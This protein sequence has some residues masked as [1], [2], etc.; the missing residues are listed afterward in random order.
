MIATLDLTHGNTC[1]TEFVLEQRFKIGGGPRAAAEQVQTEGS[2]FGEGVAGKVR[3]RKQAHTGDTASV[4]KLVPTGFAE[5]VQAVETAPA[6]ARGRLRK[7]RRS[8]ALLRSTP[9]RSFL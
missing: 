7:L 8:R 9:P 3:F 2:V 4:G 1:G 6:F 5:R